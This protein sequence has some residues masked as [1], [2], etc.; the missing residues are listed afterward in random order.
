MARLGLIGCAGTEFNQICTDYHRNEIGYTYKLIET[1]NVI[2]SKAQCSLSTFMS[3]LTNADCCY[4]L[5]VKGSDLCSVEVPEALPWTKV[6]RFYQR[7]SSG[8]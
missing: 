5:A 3:N 1:N 8:S 6:G 4:I 2:P 7:H